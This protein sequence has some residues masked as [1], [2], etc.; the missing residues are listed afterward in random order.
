M[1]SKYRGHIPEGPRRFSSD[2]GEYNSS[3]RDRD[4]MAGGYRE[5]SP[6][7]DPYRDDRRDERDRPEYRNHSDR[8]YNS[9]SRSP[10]GEFMQ[11]GENNYRPDY[12][13][14]IRSA[15]HSSPTRATR[16][17]KGNSTLYALLNYPTIYL[18]NRCSIL[19]I[20]LT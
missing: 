16:P 8:S 5:R 9:G 19:V 10:R 4:T 13:I 17:S 2:R 12:S 18:A 6:R 11:A 1:T 7:G 14:G 15:R 20:S 3:P